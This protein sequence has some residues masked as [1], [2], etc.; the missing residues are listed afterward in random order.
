MFVLT[1]FNLIRYNKIELNWEVFFISKYD[2]FKWCV[3]TLGDFYEL[4]LVEV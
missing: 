4:Q 3:V 2:E 1:T